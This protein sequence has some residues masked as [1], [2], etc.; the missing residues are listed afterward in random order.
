MTT[1]ITSINRWIIVI[2]DYFINRYNRLFI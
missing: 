2:I 1:K